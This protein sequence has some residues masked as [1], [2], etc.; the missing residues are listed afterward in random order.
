MVGSLC[1]SMP[2]YLVL[3]I[4]GVPFL[5]G[6]AKHSHPTPKGGARFYHVWRLVPIA[7]KWPMTKKTFSRVP[8]RNGPSYSLSN[9]ALPSSSEDADF[10]CSTF[11]RMAAVIRVRPLG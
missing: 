5:S 1:T 6:W 3:F 9:T 7:F 10:G 2:I 4:K 8:S 11:Q